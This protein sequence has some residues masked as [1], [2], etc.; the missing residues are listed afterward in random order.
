MITLDA[1][2]I[3]LAAASL[4]VIYL[5]MVSRWIETECRKIYPEAM[6]PQAPLPHRSFVAKPA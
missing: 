2:L 5:W 1:L 4:P 6:R 3:F